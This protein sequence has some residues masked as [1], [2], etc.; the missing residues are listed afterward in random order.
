MKSPLLS[1]LLFFF[2]PAMYAQQA[3]LDSLYQDLPGSRA[4]ERCNLYLQIAK[5]Y[6]YLPQARD[7]FLLYANL[8]LEAAEKLKID[9]LRQKALFIKGTALGLTGEYISSLSYLEKADSIAIAMQ[10][11]AAI[12]STK[13]AIGITYYYTGQLD[14]AMEAYLQAAVQSERLNLF[15][16]L[17]PAYNNISNILS[18]QERYEEALTYYQKSISLART[19]NDPLRELSTLTNA[20][21]CYYRLGMV[22]SAF[23]LTEYLG[24]KSKSIGYQEGVARSYIRLASFYNEEEKPEQAI[25]IADQLLLE[26]GDYAL[27]YIFNGYY[28]KAIAQQK[29]G[30]IE[31]SLS[32]AQKCLSI[33]QQSNSATHF[34]NS[35][36]L[37]SNLY[38]ET[39]RYEEALSY[40]KSFTHL[41]DS[42]LGEKNSAQIINLQQLYEK[43]R[44]ENQITSLSQANLR[45]KTQIK[46]RN[47]IILL[48]LFGILFIGISFYFFNQRAR[49]KTEQ[50]KLLLARRLW[51]AQLNPHFFFNTLSAVQNLIE[52][53][54][55]SSAA[56]YLSRLAHLMRQT[57]DFSQNDYISLEE[58]LEL[59]DN[60][61]SLQQFRYQQQFSFEFI[62]DP[63]VDLEAITLPPMLLQ[64]FI[65]N[66][67][68]HGKIHTQEKGKIW[69]SLTTLNEQA[70]QVKIEDN[71]VGLDQEIL[72][73]G[74]A[75]A[76][77]QQRL[78]IFSKQYNKDFELAITPRSPGTSVILSLPI[79]LAF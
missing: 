33:A 27:E 18:N 36:E 73:P 2:L 53:K 1:I 34:I 74:H 70:L 48:I 60:Y 55:A 39:G 20:V 21:T 51:R 8:A 19:I 35:Y 5:Q 10:D 6:Y 17:I 54:N 69:I 52:E 25:A 22:D 72:I 45:Q 14:K 61:L 75:N 44:R 63:N 29:L 56:N 38:K 64:P 4:E 62:I 3:A 47:F 58:E 41:Q 15:N 66:A 9:H 11:S 32:N 76:M 67:I 50:E 65:E 43:E 31:L 78:K 7:S 77:T 13:N 79:K 59:L 30:L 49:I 24:E 12:A 23:I 71:G 28:E 42:L 37:L 40:Y 46:Q 26:E 16:I 57:L 68:E